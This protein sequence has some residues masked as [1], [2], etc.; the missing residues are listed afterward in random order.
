MR[1]TLMILDVDLFLKNKHTN[2]PKL[3]QTCIS[4]Q[5]TYKDGFNL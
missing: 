5:E 4:S 3:S 1:F 2:K